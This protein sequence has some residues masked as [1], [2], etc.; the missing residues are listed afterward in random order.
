MGVEAASVASHD[1]SDLLLLYSA[2][3]NLAG[4]E[5]LADSA[6]K[7][8]KTNVAFV[9]YLLTG[10][11]EA[12]A[13]LLVSTKRLPEAAMF[14]RTYLPSK[15]DDIVALWKKD[16]ASVS[17]TAADALA[18]P[19][20]NPG[21]F[22]D[23]A[24]GLQVEQMF[25]AQREGTKGSGMS[26]LE[27]LTAKDDLELNLIELIKARQGGGETKEEDPVVDNAE[28][29]AAE[30]EAKAAAEAE[31]AAAAARIAEAEK[32]AAEAAEAERLAAEAAAAESAEAEADDFG[33]D[34]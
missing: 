3:G 2:V 34:W 27:Y 28:E 1:Y 23:L 32:A 4:M 22:P 6:S 13:D 16:L 26:G 17:Q 30:A 19:S 31:A 18:T 25:L 10:N 9:A 8:G 20:S 14:V 29:A 7:N 33:D 15:I 5:R 11:V 21:K 12:C 24:I